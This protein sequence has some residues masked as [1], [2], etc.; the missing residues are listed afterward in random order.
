MLRLQ[1]PLSLLL[2]KRLPCRRLSRRSRAEEPAAAAA[3]PEAKAEEPAA[4]AAE[5]AAEQPA[6]EEEEPEV[7][8][9]IEEN[10]KIKAAVDYLREVIA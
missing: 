5:A 8:I 2:R 6:A 4:P 1:H 3:Q 7:P 9:V 10:A